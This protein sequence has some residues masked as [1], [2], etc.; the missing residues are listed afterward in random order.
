MYDTSDLGLAAYLSYKGYAFKIDKTNPRRANFSFEDRNGN[1]EEDASHYNTH[2]AK[3]EPIKY[4]N[5][6]K[7]LKNI[8]YS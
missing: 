5:E 2:Q 3:V 8:L 7:H 6:L 1:V 4:F